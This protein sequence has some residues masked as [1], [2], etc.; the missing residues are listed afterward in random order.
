LKKEEEKKAEKSGV[1]DED[2]DEN[3]DE[4]E[5]KNTNV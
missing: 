4:Y 2:S 3:F 5:S 1:L